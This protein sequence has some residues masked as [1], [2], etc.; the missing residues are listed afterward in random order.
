VKLAKKRKVP[1]RIGVNSGSVHGSRLTVHGAGCREEGRKGAQCALRNTHDELV[2][3]ALHTIR[4]FE[5]LDFRDIVVSLK[6]S[7][8]VSTVNAYRDVARQFDYPLHL[9]VT[10]SGLP[11]DA[12]I[13]S[14]VGI[15]ALLLDG[16][17]DTIRVSLTGSS[18]EEVRVGRKILSSI[19]LRY[20]GPEIISCPT[21]GRC[22]VDLV[23]IAQ[24]IEQALRKSTVHSPQSTMKG[25][26]LST[27]DRGPHAIK[28]AI[29]GCEVNGPGEARDAD[30]G[31]AAGKGCGVLFRNGKIIRRITEKDFVKELLREYRRISG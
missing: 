16:I 25:R 15:G 3:A 17:G 19:N 24:E 14:A 23:T 2:D 27:I 7:D 18:E 28:I 10:A 5:E 9:G 11:Q 4:L 13:K 26:R 21:C 1:I 6:A 30:I 20:F 8:V 22:Q 31:I 12:T 29:M